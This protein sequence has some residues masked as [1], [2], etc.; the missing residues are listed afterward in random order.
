MGD[1]KCFNNELVQADFSGLLDKYENHEGV[2]KNIM[3][4]RDI[5]NKLNDGTKIA[6]GHE[7]IIEKNKALGFAG[8]I[9]NT[10]C[11]AESEI[12]EKDERIKF[13]ENDNTV[14]RKKLD[15]NSICYE[16]EI[17]A[18]RKK[19]VRQM[20]VVKQNEKISKL[21]HNRILKFAD[22]NNKL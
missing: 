4:E 16:K 6:M 1:K 7:F 11:D 3:Y 8:T 10:L 21:V 2:L 22:R 18:A 13:L 14:L 5:Y 12:I 20:S 9:Y 15:E 17:E 19:I